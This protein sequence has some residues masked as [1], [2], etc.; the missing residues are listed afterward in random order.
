MYKHYRR[1]NNK[2]LKMNIQSVILNKKYFSFNQA[3]QY[4]DDHKIRYVTFSDHSRYYCFD[5][6]IKHKYYGFKSQF[7]CDGV[8]YIYGYKSAKDITFI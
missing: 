2:F 4:M 5:I 1:Y 7:I 8:N 3:F 6:A